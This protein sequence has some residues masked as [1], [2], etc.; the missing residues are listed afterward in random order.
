VEI[1]VIA[2]ILFGL[3]YWYL[4]NRKE[5]SSAHNTPPTVSQPPVPAPRGKSVEDIL[6]ELEQEARKSFRQ[7]QAAGPVSAPKT[8]SP[9]RPAKAKEATLRPDQE[10]SVGYVP[11]ALQTSVSEGI[12]SLPEGISS[13]SE[14]MQQEDQGREPMQIDLRQ[15]FI[16][17][18]ILERKTH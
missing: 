6:R 3:A 18:L 9:A 17:Q 2:Y 4:K 7:N 14:I 13:I 15:A 8:P 1:K 12:S 11:A 10:G 5:K 16:H